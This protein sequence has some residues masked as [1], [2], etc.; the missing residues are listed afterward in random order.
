M[1]AR[2]ARLTQEARG[3]G[4]D[5]G[6]VVTAL[7]LAATIELVVLRSAMRAAIHIPAFES[8]AEPYRA[9]AWAGRYSYYV[10]ALLLV[11]S[12]PLVVSMLWQQR[13]GAAMVAAGGVGMFAVPA[14]LARLGTGPDLLMDMLMTAAIA[15]LATVAAIAA[16]R[17]L[18]GAALTAFA[19]AFLLAGSFTIGQHAVALE[20]LGA[21]DG[22][23][24]LELAEP[25][26]L[27]FALSLPWSLAGNL[28]RRDWIAGLVAGALVYAFFAGEPATARF[29]LLWNEGLAGTYPSLIYALAAGAGAASL[30]GLIRQGRNLEAAALLLLVAGG[31]GLHSTYQ[32]GLVAVG[33]A[34]LAATPSNGRVS[35]AITSSPTF[36]DSRSNSSVA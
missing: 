13:R 11:I 25:L 23:W 7:A 29:L 28:A 21:F 27:A 16:G 35:G 4:L 12:L 33:L 5:A 1:S 31:V 9:V 32:T 26:A 20:A 19:A 34:L 36:V 18:R 3:P 6:I 17:S 15:V 22:R 8:L 30:S 14:I 10:A 24:M 2:A